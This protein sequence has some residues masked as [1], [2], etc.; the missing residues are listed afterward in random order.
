MPSDSKDLHFRPRWWAFLLALTACGAL[1]LLGNWQT[2]RASEK[3]QLAA[4]FELAERTAPIPI[5]FAPARAD[6]L[7]LKHLEARGE[8]VPKFTVL[9]DNK[10]YKGR[11]GYFVVTPLKISGSELHVLVNRGWLPAGARRE[12]IPAPI[13]PAGT[14]S[15]EGIGLAHAPRV[16]SSGQG[17]PEGKVWQGLANEDFARWSGLALQPVFLEQR[18]ALNDGLVRDWPR[19][20][21]GI[22]KHE[23]Y[24]MQWYLIAGLCL[25]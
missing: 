7:V 2:R 1:L 22:D 25:A 11:V 9:L 16:L 19:P 4:S 6:A 5:P 21:F 17:K 18:S 24:A 8:F 20:D 10:V 13:T 3:R 15:I 12:D 23:S 14:V